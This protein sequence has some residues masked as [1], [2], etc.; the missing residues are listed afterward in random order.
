MNRLDILL[1]EDNPDDRIL[2]GEMLADAAVRSFDDSE[3][4][5]S[6]IPA[7]SI[8]AALAVLGG[9]RQVDLIL[10]DLALPDSRDL[11]GLNKLG[12]YLYEIPVIILTGLNDNR[13]AVEALRKG[14]QDYLVKGRITP[15]LLVR[16]IRHALERHK[17][18]TML[19]GLSLIDEL[20]DLYNRRGFMT[21]AGEKLKTAKREKKKLIL[22]FI[23][24]DDM[25]QI[26]DLHGHNA[27]D[28]ALQAAADILR[29][30]LRDS[31]VIARIGGD[32]FAALALSA[33]AEKAAAIEERIIS[34]LAGMNADGT[35]PFVLGLS[36]GCIVESDFQNTSFSSLLE[37]AD[38]AMYRKK[39]GKKPLP[40]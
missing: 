27:G 13:K 17:L 2:L 22:F 35:L 30:S 3:P 21:I 20:T 1:I 11:G 38:A 37:K 19:R 8:K 33:K 14:A 40:Q 28:K 12:E 15:D 32:E 24:L 34:K 23:D 6:L 39:T 18:I 36:I 31:D 29:N 16:S 9:E 5:Y 7:Q 10:L 26:N 25:K 4:Q